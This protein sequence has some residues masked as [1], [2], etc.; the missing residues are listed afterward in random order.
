[1]CSYQFLHMSYLIVRQIE[2]LQLVKLFQRI[3]VQFLKVVS[4]Q[5]QND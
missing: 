1:M 5:I 2:F 4:T 3:Q